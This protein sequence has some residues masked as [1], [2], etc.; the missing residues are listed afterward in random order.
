MVAFLG[1]FAAVAL[2]TLPGPSASAKDASC[3][4][5]GGTN[6][7]VIVQTCLPEMKLLRPL[8]GGIDQPIRESD[9][10][11]IH[12]FVFEAPRPTTFETTICS[13][14]LI[15]FSVA[16]ISGISVA[17]TRLRD[18]KPGCVT[19]EFAQVTGTFSLDIHTR[20]SSARLAMRSMFIPALTPVAMWSPGVT[21]PDDVPPFIPVETMTPPPELFVPMTESGAGMPMGGMPELMAPPPH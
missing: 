2:S 16:G 8:G 15:D 17:M 20:S 7:G 3:L 6:N 12:E 11:F 5:T 9:G 19:R 4:I 10:S 18:S 14:D 21:A 1:A 13:A